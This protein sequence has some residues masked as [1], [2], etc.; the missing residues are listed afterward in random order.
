MI[1]LHHIHHRLKLLLKNLK[2]GLGLLEVQHMGR[3][4]QLHQHLLLLD[5]F[6]LKLLC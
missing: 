4:H 2:L 3:L 6:L 5:Y 1:A